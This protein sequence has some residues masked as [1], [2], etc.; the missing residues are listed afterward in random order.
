MQQHGAAQPLL[1]VHMEPFCSHGTSHANPSPLAWIHYIPLD[2]FKAHEITNHSRQP[3]LEPF[4]RSPGAPGKA[5]CRILACAYDWLAGTRRASVCPTVLVWMH[6]HG[7]STNSDAA[8]HPALLTRLVSPDGL[9]VY[10]R[11][12]MWRIMRA[13]APGL[14][15]A[16]LFVVILNLIHQSCL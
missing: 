1:R 11:E 12:N 9:N 4:L 6:A 2:H 5:M 8:Q 14:L 7:R 13:C 15:L 3:S 16:L 10:L